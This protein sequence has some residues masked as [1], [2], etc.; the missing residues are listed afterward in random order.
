MSTAGAGVVPDRPTGRRGARGRRVHAVVAVLPDGTP[1]Y[2]PIGTVLTEGARVQCH[3]CGGWYR[4]VLAHLRVHGWEQAGYRAAFGLER[5]QPLEGADTRRRRAVA[6]RVRRVV[7][8][9]VRSGF[10]AGQQRARSGELTKDAAEAARGRRQ[11]E[12]RRRKTLRT[13]ASVSPAA[14]A[15]GRRRYT[16]QWLHRTAAEAAAGLGYPDIGSL[17]RDRVAAGASLASVSREAGLHKDW[18]CRHLATVDPAAAE[19]VN[20]AE[21]EPVRR[22]ARWLPAVRELGFEDVPSY[23]VERHVV[24]RWTVHAIAKEVGLSPGTVQA[25]LDRHG[26]AWVPH[27]ATRS[28]CV[29]RASAVADRFGY[30]DIGDYLIARRAAGLSWRSIAAECGEP[31]TWLRRRAGLPN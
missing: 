11:P 17:V 31:A 12:Q 29:R 1:C 9:A 16:E 19:A 27:A 20:E 10:E 7:E 5:G 6:L 4:S 25:A 8:P 21:L 13:L 24:D 2:S 18:L 28:E 22:D 3:L 30:P 15:A 23:L 26:V 14:R